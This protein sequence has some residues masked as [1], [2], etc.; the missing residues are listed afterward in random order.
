MLRET[1]RAPFAIGQ[2]RTPRAQLGAFRRRVAKWSRMPYGCC[3]HSLTITEA[4]FPD[5]TDQVRALIREYGDTLGVDLGFQDFERELADLPGQYAAPLGRVLLAWRDGEPVGC[6]AMRPHAGT[7]CEMK[8]LYLRPAAR[9]LGCG[10]VMVKRLCAI[11][12]AQG[13]TRLRLDTLPTMV[14]ARALYRSLGFVPIPPY[15]FNPVPGTEYLELDLTA[16]PVE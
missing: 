16:A 14:E 2:S 4:R 6:A 5:D 9:G 7:A 1:I 8:R 15:I 13:Y 11:A 10:R 3:M 12:R